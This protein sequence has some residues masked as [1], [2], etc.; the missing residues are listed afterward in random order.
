MTDLI[1]LIYFNWEL[2]SLDSWGTN[3]NVLCEGLVRL[4]FHHPSHFHANK[5]VEYI[6]IRL[7]YIC[8]ASLS[9]ELYPIKGFY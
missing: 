6:L 7:F 5:V 8:I 2:R 4:R 3:A 9:Q 1:T